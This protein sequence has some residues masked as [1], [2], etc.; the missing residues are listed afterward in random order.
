MGKDGSVRLDKDIFVQND[1]TEVINGIVD[2]VK[3]NNYKNVGQI[4]K[5]WEF[6]I[7]ELAHEYYNHSKEHRILFKRELRSLIIEKIY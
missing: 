5:S 6:R 2:S 4:K 7:Q 3:E 1:V